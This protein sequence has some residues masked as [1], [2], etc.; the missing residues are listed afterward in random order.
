M[1]FKLY[2]Q[3]LQHLITRKV[4]QQKYESNILINSLRYS[5]RNN[6]LLT[7]YKQTTN[8]LKIFKKLLK[9]RFYNK[10]IK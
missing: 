3:I 9:F 10:T 4:R 6:L 1:P 5:L 8:R 7:M 2:H